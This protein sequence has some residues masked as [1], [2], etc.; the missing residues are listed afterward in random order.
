MQWVKVITKGSVI[1]DMGIMYESIDWMLEKYFLKEEQSNGRRKLYG[2]TK[3]V[4]NKFIQ[5]L[6]A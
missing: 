4:F 1:L 6:R 5:K 2:L 3:R